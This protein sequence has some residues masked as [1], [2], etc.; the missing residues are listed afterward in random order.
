MEATLEYQAAKNIK[1]MPHLPY[2]L[3]LTPR[4]FWLFPK[5]TEQ[6]RNQMSSTNENNLLA[7]NKIF[8]SIPATKFAETFQKWIEILEVVHW[9]LSLFWRRSFVKKNTCLFTLHVFVQHIFV[10]SSSAKQIVL[11]AWNLH[12]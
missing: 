12:P 9:S 1:V 6:L 2:S 10:I 3:D 7:C 5:L 4:D 11:E 8:T